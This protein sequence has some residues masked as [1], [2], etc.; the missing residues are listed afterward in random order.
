MMA[1]RSGFALGGSIRINAT[2]IP[3]GLHSRIN[4]RLFN[5]NL[6]KQIPLVLEVPGNVDK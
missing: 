2:L 6:H 4:R 5:S 3:V 1:L